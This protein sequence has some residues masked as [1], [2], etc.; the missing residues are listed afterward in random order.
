MV[1]G[2]GVDSAPSG[3]ALSKLHA[4]LHLVLGDEL[5]GGNRCLVVRKKVI[6]RRQD[7]LETAIWHLL[8]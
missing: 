8:Y 5:W 4:R 6:G 1:S 2:G 3:L 7:H